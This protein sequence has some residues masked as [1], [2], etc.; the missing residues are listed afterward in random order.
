[1]RMSQAPPNDDK[2]P[3]DGLNINARAFVPQS[4][5]TQQSSAP[6][7]LAA[8]FQPSATWQ[9]QQQQGHTNPNGDWADYECDPEAY[10]AEE[11]YY[12]ENGNFVVVE[13]GFYGE[14]EEDENG[15][16]SDEEQW[17]L[18]QVMKG[19]DEYDRIN[20]IVRNSEGVIVSV[21][22]PNVGSAGESGNSNK[23]NPS[24]L[25]NE[26]HQFASRCVEEAEES[27]GEGPE[28]E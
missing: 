2:K 11:G 15:M 6:S 9:Q 21:E 26:A 1:M 19:E 25:A 28:F 10:D 5:T 17:M 27:D 13:G 8:P 20:G 3:A 23:E 12:D 22:N 18:E 24:K 4:F 7:A 14:D 16:D